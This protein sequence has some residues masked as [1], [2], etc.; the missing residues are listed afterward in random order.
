MNRSRLN[1]IF[2]AG[3][4]L[5]GALMHIAERVVAGWTQ[6]AIAPEPQCPGQGQ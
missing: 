4:L 1:P 3:I 6:C 5:I 2:V